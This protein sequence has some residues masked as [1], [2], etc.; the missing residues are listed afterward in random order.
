MKRPTQ[1]KPVSAGPKGS[2]DLTRIMKQ[3]GC[4]PVRFTGTPGALYERHLL[5]DNVRKLTAV[6][7][8]ERFEAAARSVRDVLSQRWLR[9][10]ET[11]QRQ[12]CKR[13]YYLSM[14]FLIGRSLANNITNLLLDPAVNDVVKRSKID[15]YE[16]LEQ[17][18]DAGLGNGGLGR[19]A[20]CFLDSMATMQIPAMGYGLRYEY[21]IF[22][23][24]LQ[25]RLATGTARQLAPSIG[26]VGSR[27]SGRDGRSEAELLVRGPRR[28]LRPVIGRPSSLIGIPFDR[29]V[30]GY[31]GK[32]INTLRLWS[33]AAHE[34]F[35]FQ[36]FS[37]GDFVAA[38][39]ETLAA[40]SL[41]RVLYP[42][43]STS[44]GQASAS[45]RSTFSSPARSPISCDAS[46]LATPIGAG[47]RNRS[48]FSS[49]IRTLR[50][51]FPS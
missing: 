24:T 11:Y 7:A 34:C 23:Q 12:N 35:D 16:L 9:T 50:W 51:R 29:P 42:D 47:S 6:G 14:E 21:G 41:T 25:G 3:Y 1:A 10:E 40:E 27:A 46:A 32:T 20:A 39:A 38:L 4:G 49:T 28:T 15:W 22:R 36:E 5:F 19:L 43:D 18:P 13:V 48:P 45:C 37:H 17:E 31:G 30:V 26:P 44:I 2:A 8:R 33:A